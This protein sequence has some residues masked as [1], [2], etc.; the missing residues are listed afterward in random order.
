[1]K[2]ITVVDAEKKYKIKLN[3]PKEMLLKTFLKNL[4]EIIYGK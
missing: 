3:A 2:A 4:S 1:M